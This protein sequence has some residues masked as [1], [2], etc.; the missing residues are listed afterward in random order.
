MRR[1]ILIFSLLAI[2]LII[3]LGCSGGKNNPLSPN[4]E[5]NNAGLTAETQDSTGQSVN[6]S[7]MDTGS[8][9]P[10]DLTDAKT[11]PLQGQ[12]L[13]GA[14]QLWGLYSLAVDPVNEK[15]VMVPLRAANLHLNTLKFLEPVGGP[16]MVQIAGPLQWNTDHTI[17]D[18]DL[19]LVHPFA[20]ALQ[21][22]GF[23]VRGIMIT[24]GTRNGFTDPSL[25]MANT[26]ETR[27]LNP[28]GYTRWWNPTEFP[29]NGIF[30]Y[31]DGRLGTK[32]SVANFESTMN[33]YKIFADTLQANT[34]LATMDPADRGVFRAGHSN[35]RHYKISLKS[36]F[37]FNYAIDASWEA[38][39]VVPPV[40]PKDFPAN[41]NMPDPRL[42]TTSDN[43][44]TLYYVSPSSNG[45]LLTVDIHVYDWQSPLPDTSLGTVKRVVVE[46]P[47]L[48]MPV[49][50]TYISDQG[51]YALYRA[52]V[53]PIANG[54][55]STNNIEY[56]VWAESTDG[57]G[58]GG[59][60]P[61]STK[62]ISMNRF[63]ATVSSVKPNTP[64]Q[65]TAGVTGNA[66]PGLKSEHYTVTA[67]DPDGDTLTW[68]W[69]VE[70]LGNPFLFDDP[71]NGDGTIDINWALLGF[72]SYTVQAQVSDG[73]NPAVQATALDVSVGNKPPV[74][75][76]ITGPLAVNASNTAAKYTVTESDPDLGQT[77]TN[78]WSFVP[79]L[80]PPNY[81]IAALPDGSM[82]VN[83]STIAPGQYDINVQVSDGFAQVTSTLVVVTHSNTLPTV[84][85]VTGKTP[86]TTLDTSALYSAPW[87]DPDTTQ[88]LTFK[89]S[90]V[91]TGNAA[92][93]V[94]NSNPDGSINIDWST[95]AVGVY[96]LNL[97]AND[98][99][100]VKTGSK[101][102]V[103]KNN[104]VPI[105]GQV[106]GP[107]AVS[108][109][110]TAAK[111]TAPMSD[112]DTDQTLTATWS[113][114]LSGDAPVFNIA[115]QPD[116]SA[117]INWSTYADGFYDV[118]VRVSDGFA[119]IEGMKLVVQ[120]QD[121]QP[122]TVGQVAGPTPVHH[123]NTAS[124]YTCPIS[125]PNGDPLSVNWSVVPHGNLAVYN[126]PGNAT[127]PLVMDWSTKPNLGD[128]DINVQASDGVNPVVT[129]TML[130]VTLANTVP[131]VGPCDG[132][133]SVDSTFTAAH[134]TVTYSDIDAGQTLTVQWS[135]VPHLS[136]ASYTIA[137]NPDGSLDYN[138]ASAAVG[139]Y[140]VAVRV[141]DGFGNSTC[142]PINVT[143]ANLL[144]IAGVV[145]GKSPVLCTD[146][147]TNYSAPYSDPDPSQ[148]LTVMWSVVPNGNAPSYV[149]SSKPNGSVDINWS[150][151][152]VGLYDVNMRVSDGIANVEG[153]LLT[154]NRANSAPVVGS[155]TG[156][157]SVSCTDTASKYQASHSDCDTGQVLSIHW[158]LVPEGFSPAYV[159]PA[160]P[161]GSF[162]N[163]W[164][165]TPI[166]NYDIS[167][168][169]DDGIAIVNS[170]VLTV[171]KLNTA[172]VPGAVTGPT[173]VT[174]VSIM[175]YA[176]NPAPSDCD[177]F[178]TLTY[179]Y[180]IVAQGN[181][182]VYNIS[183][184]TG[185][186]TVDWSVY[187]VG[188]W[189]I[190]L[191]VS[192]GITN[193]YSTPLDVV[194]NL[195]VCT[196]TA[197]TFLSTL[198]PNPYSVTALSILPR[199]DIAFI[200]GGPAGIAGMGLVQIGPSTLGCF[201]ASSPGTSNVLF[202]YFLGKKDTAMSIDSDSVS[203]RVLVV[204]LSEPSVLKIIDS[205][206]I[207]GG[208]IIGT[209]DTGSPSITWVAVDVDSNGDFWAVQR[210]STAGVV[211]SLVHY[212]YLAD[213]P[214]YTYDPSGTLAI[215]PKV[216]TNTDI[217]DIAINQSGRFLYILEAGASSRG[218]LH[219]Y[220]LNVGS[221]PTFQSSQTN[222]FSQTLAYDSGGPTGFAGYADIDIDHIDTTQER[223]R[224]LVFG[225]L[226]DGTSE[227]IRM[228][229]DFTVLDTES[230]SQGWPAFAINPNPN[231]NMR[232]LIMPD[233][234]SLGFW[235]PPASW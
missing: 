220:K 111:Y 167:V 98:G 229:T 211:Y 75:G 180:S 235:S 217:F 102:V 32:D 57:A 153:T 184:G 205:S 128:Y 31:R 138:W 52:T 233:A 157:L 207:I 171:T 43:L 48:F 7:A 149:I 221:F 16:G 104:T 97:Q 212:T 129:G 33:G 230:G 72:G 64:P 163:D 178:Q 126:I 35:I 44:N 107:E 115:S 210:D 28:D 56:V 112:I 158:S 209:I 222:L 94:L 61:T 200:D 86:V 95:H 154:V 122:P 117:S 20:G 133:V 183:S 120:K 76:P 6:P 165:N 169:L 8:N 174:N 34:D 198:T 160:S 42:I 182:P 189:T 46:W 214:Y 110:D 9:D 67:N 103:T 208:P 73:V 177:S 137:A 15:I 92:S 159:I 124:Q 130:V 206:I 164:S 197:H 196:G 181:T 172:P 39:T 37:L 41:A 68:S 147:V 14:H 201:D 109:A 226:I 176:P 202:K 51:T 17:L 106:A 192:D 187:G 29:G 66:S 145:S 53:S 62:L 21:L 151:Y 134:Y 87:S 59:I 142:G 99:I 55:K 11:N 22:S 119:Q 105:V 60:L 74:V 225:R 218:V 113:V 204:T 116:K 156:P 136:P 175:D 4:V 123:S 5:N 18:L 232:N 30:S 223:C 78:L 131:A 143:K 63:E 140:D 185:Q 108:S 139:A 190:G 146:T 152:S 132:P 82:D 155:V 234:G 50:A 10:L 81:S 203:G 70:V 150:T 83:Y 179:T 100:G 168:R 231:V 228:T 96:D 49:E 12:P 40:V 19:R 2:L 199:K 219:S 127:D 195:P 148:T 93:Y 162:T 216:G 80:S 88:T 23:D 215:T 121:N 54:L 84:G 13:Q 38:P 144:P 118:N 71:G 69:S 193:S 79:H 58:Y 25:V 213:T 166:G 90:L 141:S 65:I 27:L 191:Q 89:W 26:N 77:L 135:V 101:L 24:K 173:P 85:Q 170:P 45:G 188:V 3:S 186:I 227:L 114:V 1:S 125:D 47:G 224:L 194:V 36:G 91:P 161:D